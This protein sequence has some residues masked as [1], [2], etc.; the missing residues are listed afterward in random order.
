MT[1]KRRILFIN[2]VDVYSEEFMNSN[3]YIVKQ[4]F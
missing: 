3:K 2:G 4:R 1:K